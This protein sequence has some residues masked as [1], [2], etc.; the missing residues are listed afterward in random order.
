[1]NDLCDY[2][3]AED[4]SL[5][6]NDATSFDVDLSENDELADWAE[7]PPNAATLSEG[8]RESISHVDDAF[9]RMRILANTG[10]SIVDTEEEGLADPVHLPNRPRIQGECGQ[11]TKARARGPY[12]RY[13]PQQI[14]KLFDLVIEEGRTAKEAGLIMGINVRTA[15][16]YIESYNR[17]EE[18]CLPGVQRKPRTRC[19]DYVD[20]N[21]TAILTDIK[22]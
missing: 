12:R 8:W 22:R 2:M 18:R 1:M 14:E 3:E 7:L 16:R 17:D 11:A 19:Y 13:T 21:P 4:A 6:V 5:S 15:Q 20:R 9:V 10:L